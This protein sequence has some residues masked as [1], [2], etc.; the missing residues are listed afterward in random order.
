MNAF[1]AVAFFLRFAIGLAVTSA[2]VVWA[3]YSPLAMAILGIGSLV[4]LTFGAIYLVER[5]RF[6]RAQGKGGRSE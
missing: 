3:S 1:Q 4:F 6:A 2:L 5:D